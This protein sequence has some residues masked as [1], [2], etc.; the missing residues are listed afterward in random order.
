MLDLFVVFGLFHYCVDL[1]QKAKQQHEWSKGYSSE[2]KNF[3]TEHIRIVIPSAD[4]KNKTRDDYPKTD[5]KKLIVIF[6]QG[7]TGISGGFIFNLSPF[8]CHENMV[9]SR[10]WYLY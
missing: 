2:T 4:H 8:F 5:G 7:K 10:F 1:K 9:L 6:S 3:V